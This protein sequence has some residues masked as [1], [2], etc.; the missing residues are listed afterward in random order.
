MEKQ[1]PPREMPS[2]LLTAPE[3]RKALPPPRRAS[4]LGWLWLLVLLALAVAGWYLWSRGSINTTPAAGGS[5]KSGKK[6][7]GGAVPVVAVQA[8]KGN[9]RV[10]INGPGTITPLNTVTVKSR[11]DG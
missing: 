11:V 5:P 10:Y 3:E 4:K 2:K 9:I 7:G 1:A 6:G 8:Q